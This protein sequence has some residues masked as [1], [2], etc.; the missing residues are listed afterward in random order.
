MVHYLAGQQDT[1]TCLSLS[2]IRHQFLSVQPLGATLM[3]T[4]LSFVFSVL[5]PCQVTRTSR[6]GLCL[7]YDLAPDSLPHFSHLLPLNSTGQLH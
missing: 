3:P 6:L 7:T 2:P 1:L 4:F 5:R